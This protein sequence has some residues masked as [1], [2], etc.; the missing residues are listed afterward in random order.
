[1]QVGDFL[2]TL[3]VISVWITFWNFHQESTQIFVAKAIICE[4]HQPSN[5]SLLSSCYR[6]LCQIT[7]LGWRQKFGVPTMPRTN[8]E[9]LVKLG[10]HNFH[11]KTGQA[12]YGVLDKTDDC[13]VCSQYQKNVGTRYSR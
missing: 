11:L 2:D 4:V 13:A 6:V 9:S 7:I 12:C 3:K 1:M 5:Q 8:T 10:K